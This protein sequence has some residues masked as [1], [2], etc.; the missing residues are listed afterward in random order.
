MK[1]N[2]YIINNIKYLNSKKKLV[3]LDR[4]MELSDFSKKNAIVNDKYKLISHVQ[5]LR[6]LVVLEGDGEL[7]VNSKIEFV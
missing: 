1:N 6:S 2:K 7:L 4:E 3:C 5:H